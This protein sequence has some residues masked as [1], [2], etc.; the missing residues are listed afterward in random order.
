MR[1]SSPS[2]RKLP[3]LALAVLFG[4]A[5]PAVGL[6]VPD[7]VRIPKARE[8]GQGEPPDAALFS[9]WAHDTYTCASCH[10]GT[11]P[12][13]KLG[14]THADMDKGRFCGSCHDGR[15]AFGPKDRG[16]ECETCHVPTAP[17]R[18]IDEDQLWND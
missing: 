12:Q 14:F 4:L 11:F 10:P 15:T 3:W 7:R 16:V 5:G 6:G 18:E 1:P 9:H 2:S 17:K 13:R 8:H